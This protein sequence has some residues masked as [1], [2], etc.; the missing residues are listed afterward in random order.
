MQS[1]KRTMRDKKVLLHEENMGETQ[2]KQSEIKCNAIQCYNKP[3]KMVHGLENTH[4]KCYGNKQMM[5]MLK[6]VLTK[7]AQTHIEGTCCW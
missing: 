6:M 3:S 1:I 5:A 2:E 4:A 7:C